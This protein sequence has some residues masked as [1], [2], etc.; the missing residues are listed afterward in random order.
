MSL[1]SELR[2]IGAEASLSDDISNALLSSGLRSTRQRVALLEL[3]LA[4]M[5]HHITAEI[6]Y[7]EAYQA[8]YR[9][10][11]ATVCSTLRQFAQAGLVRRI[12]APKS[13]K[14]WFVIDR[15]AI[16]KAR[17]RRSK[18]YIAISII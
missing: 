1:H 11:R 18:N 14:A 9:V 3:L 10:S 5:D 15:R 12:N 8:H 7:E 13:P 6:L 17:N 4:T 2:S 16:E